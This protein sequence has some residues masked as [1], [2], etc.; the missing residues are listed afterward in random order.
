MPDE[1]ALFQTSGM[2]WSERARLDEL[3]AVLTGCGNHVRNHFLHSTQLFAAHRALRFL[4]A[5]GRVIDFGCGTG[6]FTR[7]FGSRGFEVL[8]TEITKEM[9][10]RA[11][12][13]GL[14]RG[15]D[16]V[17]TDG[18]MIPV[19]P[20]SVDM[21]WVCTVLR[22]SL[23]VPNPVYDQIAQEMF[24]VLKPGGRVVNVEMY[25][26][27]PAADFIHGFET[28]GFQTETVRVVNRHEGPFERFIQ[29]RSIPLRLLGI[30]ARLCAFYRFHCD[31]AGAAS[32]GLRD[33]YFC[34][35]K[36]AEGSA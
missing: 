1:K 4:P 11:I 33:Y 18:I 29:K 28:A 24:R 9:A 5:N 10:E 19:D 25:V 35:R 23:N 2:T 7:F 34:W 14:P 8:A 36:P 12:E 6:R 27:Q 16:V 3:D 17:V 20:G 21:V 32:P 30:V 22:Y 31:S 13:L 26:E 15:S